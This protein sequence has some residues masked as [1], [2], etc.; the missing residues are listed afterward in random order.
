MYY[1]YFHI[2]IC[3]N[4]EDIYA[5]THTHVY[6]YIYIYIYIYTYKRYNDKLLS[7][8]TLKAKIPSLLPSIL[9]RGTASTRPMHTYMNV[10]ILLLHF[11]YSNKLSR[12]KTVIQM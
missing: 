12:G 11:Y 2:C 4:Y 8:S 6:I 1:I 3:R 9:G 7:K 10:D 5:H